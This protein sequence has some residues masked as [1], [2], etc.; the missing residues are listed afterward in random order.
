MT[1]LTG[2]ICKFCALIALAVI[3]VIFSLQALLL[4]EKGGKI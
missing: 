1:T 4:K 3:F 2:I